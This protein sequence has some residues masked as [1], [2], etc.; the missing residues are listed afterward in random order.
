ML[1]SKVYLMERADGTASV[2]VG[3]H[4]LTAFAL[5]GLNG[6]AGVLLE[7]RSSSAEFDAIRAHIDE[8]ARQAVAYDRSMKDAYAWWAE[9]YIEGLAGRFKDR[10]RDAASQRTMVVMAEC[11]G[12]DA[13][14]PEDALYF[15][16]PEAIDTITS[17]QTEVHVFLFDK[18]PPTP[19][20]G[21]NHLDKAKQALKCRTTGLEDDGGGRE[22][23]ADWEISNRV[24]PVLRKTV[25]PFRP[26]ARPGMRQI[27]V[28]VSDE[29]LGPFEY[30]FEDD[31]ATWLPS[32]DTEELA[33]GA[34]TERVEYRP[35]GTGEAWYRVNG[36]VRVGAGGRT[37]RP[38]RAALM[39]M[40][41]E[42]GNYILMSLRR[43]RRDVE[44]VK[45]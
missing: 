21:L 43:R 33:A 13:P 34:V 1:H 31:R 25:A 15:E 18:L 5:E 30:L 22:L 35:S 12:P 20:L 39:D 2:F 16:I 42:S 40:T 44:S 37:A 23:D 36:L 9:Q 29:A 38:D 17:V 7:G 6:E 11:N 8:A 41:P 3:S 26:S 27:R 10:P 14:G 4:N 45:D 32:L 24:K 19:A 28:R